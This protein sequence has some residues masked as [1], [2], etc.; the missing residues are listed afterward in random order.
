MKLRPCRPGQ[1]TGRWSAFRRSAHHRLRI[2][3]EWAQDRRVLAASLVY[4]VPGVHLHQAL[5]SRPRHPGRLFSARQ[6][7][8]LAECTTAH[9]DLDDLYLLGPVTARRWRLRVPRYDIT[10]ERWTVLAAGNLPGPDLLELS[11]RAE[12]EDAALIQPAFLASIR[13]QG[14]GPLRLPADQNPARAPAPRYLR[15]GIGRPMWGFPRSAPALPR[16][17]MSSQADRRRGRVL[18]D[19]PKGRRV[20]DPDSCLGNAVQF[21]ASPRQSSHG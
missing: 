8:Y 15:L 13:L 9:V 12:P 21:N 10:A 18:A 11:I 1:L 3:G 20:D 19:H 17:M 5:L 16:R 7:R 4:S 6:R 14:T 2:E